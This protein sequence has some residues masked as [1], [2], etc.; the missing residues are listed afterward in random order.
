MKYNLIRNAYF[1]S[2][3]TGGT[4]NVDLIWTQLESLMDQ[5]FTS[6]GVT[7]TTSGILYLETDLSQRIKVDGIRLY[8]SDLSKS[9]DVNFYYKN[10]ES[11][12]YT[13]L[14]TYSGASYYYT[15]IAS[16]S[17]PQFMRVTVSGIAVELYE[18]LIYNDDYIVAFGEDGQTYAEYIDNSPVG[19][20]GDSQAVAIFNNDASGWPATGYTT[21]D[22]TGTDADNYIKISP[23]KN[24]IYRG[25][26]DGVLIEDNNGA[27][28]YIWDMGEYIDTEIDNNKL[29]ITDIDLGQKLGHLPNGTAAESFGTGANTWDWDRVNKKMYVMGLEGTALSLWDYDYT[30]DTW[31]YLTN[32]APAVAASPRFAVMS[33]CDGAIY[34]ISKFDGTFG[35]YT[36]SGAVDNWTSLPNPTFSGVVI[37]QYGRV[38]MCSDGVRYIYALT[39]EY[40]QDTLNRNFRRF[41]TVSGTWASMDDGYRQYDYVG[42][43]SA[44]FTNTSCLTYDYDKDRVYLINASEEVPHPTNHYIQLYNVSADSWGTNWFDVTTVYNTTYVVESIW[45][46]NKWLYV[47]CNPHFDTGYFFRYGLDTTEVEK[48]NLGYAHYDPDKSGIIGVYMIA[49]DNDD[50]FGASVYFAQIDADRSYLYS[51][52]VQEDLSGTYTAPILKMG[53]AY[54]SSYFVVDATTT[55]GNYVTSVSYDA[56]SYNGT[57]RVRSSNTGPLV[58]DEIYWGHRNASFETYTAKEII[59]NG[60]EDNDF[61]QVTTNPYRYPLGMAVNRRDGAIAFV[62]YHSQSNYQGGCLYVYDRAGNFLG[63]EAHEYLY[64]Q[65]RCDVNVEFDKWGGLWGYGAYHKYLVH[66]SKNLAS[67]LY[68]LNDGTDFLYDLAVE[69]DGA[70]VWYTNKSLNVVYHLD[71]NGNTLNQIVLQTPR[72]ICGT[73]DNGCWVMDNT[74]LKVYRYAFNGDLVK[75]I[76]LERIATRM[77]TDMV[78]GFWY[79]KDDSVYHVNSDGVEDV[80]VSAG[81]SLTKIKGGHSGCIVWSES[82]NWIKYID[83]NGNVTRTFT[84]PSGIGLTGYPDLFSFRYEDFAEF[85][86]TSNIIPVSYDPVW[87]TNGSVEWKEVRKDGY[88]LP[89]KQYHQV[90]LTLRT[91]DVRYTPYV[92]KLLMAPAI[93]IEDISSKSY[94]NMYIKTDIPSGADVADYESKLK[95]WWQIEA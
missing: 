47:S 63:G 48:L 64:P 87:G 73:S 27:S 70:G 74:D 22:Y 94:K 26:A 36:I 79:I 39:S 54:S 34:V 71:T 60:V 8:A 44:S 15:T 77:C 83:N 41:D 65:L 67:K 80:S 69:M 28:T 38:S 57:I 56:G 3:T 5:N 55:S 81:P 23:S 88:F 51:Y 43:V 19:E 14:T 84:D 49:I 45:Y 52:N 35:K 32:L 76:S 90:E 40:G 13:S 17:A 37:D 2:L 59:Y 50:F 62:F 89:K 72:A 66:Y 7:L 78:D 12:S 24:G 86:D 33:Y 75:T 82:N 10:T 9:S 1:R 18:F 53:D 30:S 85:Q 31:D 91:T 46:H 16:P 58:V 20:V 42:G 92:N 4:G 93:K 11:D 21:I 95:A 61:I 29:K 6:S 68:E 25:L